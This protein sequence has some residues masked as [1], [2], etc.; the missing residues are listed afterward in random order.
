M[1]SGGLAKRFD[2]GEQRRLRLMGSFQNLFNH[3]NYSNPASSISVPAQVG[4]I[5]GTL[6]TEGSGSRTIELSARLEF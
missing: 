6:G 2:F 5:T 4:R 1:W 3:P